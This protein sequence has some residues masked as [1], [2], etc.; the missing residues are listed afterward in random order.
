[1]ATRSRSK[2]TTRYVAL[3][4][5]INVG[6]HNKVSMRTLKTVFESLGLEHVSTY[7][8]S[9]NVIF[10]TSKKEEELVPMIQRAFHK[11]FSF[12][13]QI[14]L[15]SAKQINALVKKIPQTWK[16]DPKQRT[17]VLFL[18][19]EFDKKGTLALIAQNPEVDR[20]RYITGSIVWNFEKVD[21][22]KS[23]MHKFIGTAVY[24]KMT[25][26]NVNTV[27]KLDE[28]MKKEV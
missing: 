12:D 28:L 19:E 26:R 15:R 22:K 7:I 13:I 17:D 20:L 10:A 27:R 2:E 9:G 1:M 18:W 25:A 6:G 3:L 14:L 23:K 21:Y 8:N 11:E 16:N 5:G 24:K 4:R